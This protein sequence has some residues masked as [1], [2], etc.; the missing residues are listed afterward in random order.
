MKNIQPIV[1]NDNCTQCGTCFAVCPVDAIQMKYSDRRG[2]IPD[3]NQKVCTNC[4]KCLRVCP[5]EELDLNALTRQVF[6]KLPQNPLYGVYR[7]VYTGYSTNKQIRYNGASGGLV[8]TILYELLKDK[9]IDGA[10]VVKMSQDRPLEPDIFIARSLD[11]LISAQQ[12]KYL[13]VPMNVGLREIMKDT[14]GRYA[15]VGLPC[16]FHGLRLMERLNNKL[17][18]RIVLRIGL[19]C[20]F[21]PTMA[22]TKFLLRRAG[23]KDFSTVKK[24]KYR[25]GDWPCGFRA[26]L[27]DGTDRFLYPIK[28]FLFSH[29]LFE[30]Q[31]CAMCMD[32][33]CEL[34][35]MSLGDEWRA[36]LKSSAAGW[37]FLM[38]RTKVA[39]QFVEKLVRKSSVY[40]EEISPDIIA[41]GQ[42]ATMIYKKRGT[43]A[44]AKIRS[45]MGKKVPNYLRNSKYQPKLR[46]YIGAA[47]VYFIPA[48]FEK[49]FFS[50]M[51]IWVP[52]NIY[53]KY[54][55]AILRFFRE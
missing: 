13:P 37:S 44:F 25:D 31:R 22:S 38:T 48:L 11:D 53:N 1:E 26:Y 39:D 9:D 41:S 28:H 15:V 34:A 43:K 6:G 32:H 2:L 4:K 42:A 50:R 30:R 7:K 51:F 35:D 46:Y 23:V 10:M 3:V 49:D 29:Y 36:D 17:K 27:K 19:F 45:L 55:N 33:L 40:L 5:G 54:R 8:T 20:G 21:N 14:N 52:T 12:S 16:H 18:D 24:I 47:L